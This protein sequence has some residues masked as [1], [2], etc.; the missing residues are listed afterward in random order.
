MNYESDEEET[1]RNEDE[2]MEETKEAA[3]GRE[4]DRG[5]DNVRGKGTRGRPRGRGPKCFS[6]IAVHP[7]F[8]HQS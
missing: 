7:F 1:T 5:K 6:W 3:R 4:V 2:E 8:H